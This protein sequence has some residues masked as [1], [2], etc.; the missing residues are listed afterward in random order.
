[1]NDKEIEQLES[2]VDDGNFQV[3]WIPDPNEA[4][5]ITRVSKAPPPDEGDVEEPSLVA[6]TE[7]GK[8][9]ALYNADF[10]EFFMVNPLSSLFE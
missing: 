5:R 7:D 8:Y 6:Y 3:Y 4:K 10:N 9:I 2:A 1:M